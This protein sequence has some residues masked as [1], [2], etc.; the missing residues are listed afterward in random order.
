MRST[1]VSLYFPRSSETL[2]CQSP[3]LSQSHLDRVDY[4]SSVDRRKR[5]GLSL[6]SMESIVDEEEDVK[7]VIFINLPQAEF[8]GSTCIQDLTYIHL[9]QLRTIAEPQEKVCISRAAF[10]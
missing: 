9:A 1:S 2:A 7:D 4:L 6:T 3:S 5:M 10:T 8:K